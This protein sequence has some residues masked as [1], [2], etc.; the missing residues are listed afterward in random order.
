MMSQRDLRADDD[1][2]LSVS[3]Q[4]CS[5]LEVNSCGDTRAYCSCIPMVEI[6]ADTLKCD[7]EVD[8]EE[9]SQG[10]SRHVR[11]W[12]GLLAMVW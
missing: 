7:L 4:W 1:G 2:I 6:I 8:L 3:F 10:V 12:K 5:I 11:G 9:P